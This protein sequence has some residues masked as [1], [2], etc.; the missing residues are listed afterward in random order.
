MEN[1]KFK[2]NFI[3]A[4]VLL[5][6]CLC[7]TLALAA[8]HAVTQPLID[9]NA[10]KAANEARALVLPEGDGFTEYDGSLLEGV[11]DCYIANNGVG[12]AVTSHYKGFGGDVKVMTGIDA[13]GQITGVTVT[14]HSE[15]PGLG[16]KDMTPEYLAQYSGV[17]EAP[18][19]SISDDANIDAVTGATISANAIYNSVGEALAQ[20]ESC[21]GVN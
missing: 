14:E 21:G 6:I 5:C 11:D 1:N 17:S 19:A 16:T 10:E 3:P 15:T 9:A 7:A 12:M 4:I 2:E 8:T 20:F 13:N 18:E